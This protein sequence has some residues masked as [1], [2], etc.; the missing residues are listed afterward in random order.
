MDAAPRY[1]VGA[2]ANCESPAVTVKNPL[3]CS[4]ACQQAAKL[5]RYVRA[6]RAQGTH[7]RPDI[8][9]AIEMKMAHVLAGGYPETERR[10]PAA[11]RAEVFRRAG[12]RCQ[13]CGRPLA[14]EFSTLD[15]GALF[16][17]QH[18]AGD[19]NSISNLQA[20]CRRCNM[21]DAKAN[22]VR[23]HPSSLHA[24]QAAELE[25]R[26][27]SPE[28][29]RLCDDHTQWASVWRHKKRAAREVVRSRLSGAVAAY[30]DD[31]P[32]S[33]D[34]MA[35]QKSEVPRSG[36]ACRSSRSKR[37]VSTEEVVRAVYWTRQNLGRHD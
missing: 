15:S 4:S 31:E 33:S 11:I 26:W 27:L 37:I 34:I 23:I 36:K 17:V 8:V 1:I 12:G 9:E 18:V 7:Q 16:T 21:A 3:W 20:F 19:S 13:N 25:A 2:C 35:R 30:P 29:L 24:A 14:L 22:F 32:T 5:V 10:V 6:R 28:P